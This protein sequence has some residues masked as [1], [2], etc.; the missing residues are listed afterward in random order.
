M[1]LE[2]TLTHE[3]W[4]RAVVAAGLVVLV[5]LGLWVVQEHRRPWRTWQ[6]RAR[7]LHVL[8][9]GLEG[10]VELPSAHG[11]VDRCATCHV[12]CVA[13]IVARNGLP[14]ALPLAVHPPLSPTHAPERLGC[15]ACHGGNGLALDPAVAHADPETGERDTRLRTPWMQ[16][17]CVACHVPGAVPGTERLV[18]GAAVF[19]GLGCGMCHGLGDDGGGASE[20]GTSLRTAPPSTLADARQR[21]LDPR[22]LS[23]DN[24]MPAFRMSLGSRPDDLDNLVLFVRALREPKVA[25]T[26]AVP[27]CDLCHHDAKSRGA[28]HRCVYLRERGAELRCQSCHPVALPEGSARCPVVNAHAAACGACHADAVGAY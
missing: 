18:R 22:V 4:S 27:S 3:R 28:S 9:D 5:L 11:G 8:P 24:S 13:A 6:R 19:L 14:I 7:T 17:R 20:E 25:P 15:T 16:S 26:I 10:V 2:R 23:P 12:Q 1:A 21:M